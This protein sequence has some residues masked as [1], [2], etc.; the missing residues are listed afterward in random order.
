MNEKPPPRNPVTHENHRR[1]V[2]WQ[3]T[4]PLVLGLLLILGLAVWTVI[5]V[6]DG[7]SVSLW[8]D[9]SLIYLILPTMLMALI[10]LLLIAALAYGIIWLNNNLPP[11]ARQAQDAF[12]RVRVSV[13]KISD[14]VVKPIIRL[15]SAWAG[16]QALRRK[17]QS[18]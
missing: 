12:I 15:R 1:Q 9:I 6:A 10:P 5:A 3:V 17:S 8:A 4:I 11:Y 14:Q 7:E 16:V 2:F 18:S 13:Q